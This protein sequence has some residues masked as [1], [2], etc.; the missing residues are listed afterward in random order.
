MIGSP[1]GPSQQ[2]TETRQKLIMNTELSAVG[3]WLVH[4]VLER[5]SVRMLEPVLS[6]ISSSNVVII[7]NVYEMS[8]ALCSKAWHSALYTYGRNRMSRGTRSKII[9]GL[10]NTKTRFS[11]NVHDSVFWEVMFH[12]WVRYSWHYPVGTGGMKNTLFMHHDPWNTTQ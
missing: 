12:R 5:Y 1:S 3:W 6:R 8:T 9:Y 10:L 11:K 2:S 4:T 7:F